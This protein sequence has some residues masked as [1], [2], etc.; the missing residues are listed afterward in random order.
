MG[1][2]HHKNREE[3]AI[4]EMQIRAA[5]EYPAKFSVLYDKYYKFLFL[6]IFKR[7]RE[8]ELTAD[9]TSQVFLKA[10]LHLKKYQFRGLPFSAWLFRIALNE[11]HSHYRKQKNHRTISID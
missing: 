7:T 9:I 4:E 6:F 3:I 11:I 10:M 1:E 2:R 5:Q 8:E